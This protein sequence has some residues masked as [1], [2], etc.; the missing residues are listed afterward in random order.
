MFGIARLNTLAKAVSDALALSNFAYKSRLDNANAFNTSSNDNFGNNLGVSDTHVIVGAANEDDADGQ[1]TGKAYVYNLATGSLVYTFTNPNP[2]APST[3]DQFGWDVD[4]STN[5]AIVSAPFEDETGQNDAGKVYV[6]SMSTGTLT[7]TFNNPNIYPTAGLD[8]FGDQVA[9]AENYAL[10]GTL[11]DDPAGVGQGGA[12]FLYELATGTRVRTF[13]VASPVSN[14]YFGQAVDLT[15]TYSIVGAPG[16][17][18][19]SGAAYIYTNS[20][21]ALLYTLTNPNANTANSADGFG[22]SVALTNTHAIVG[23]PQEDDASGTS[24]GKAYVFR[25]SDGALVWTL[26]NPNAFG[27]S[28]ND[29]FGEKVSISDTHVLVSARSEADAGGSGSGKAYI[30]RISDGA[31]ETT[32]NNPNAFGTTL[33]D[34]FSLALGM[35]NTRAVISAYFEGDGGSNPT[36]SGTVGSGKAYIY[37]RI[38]SEQVS[39]P[40]AYGLVLTSEA[41]STAAT[42]V[43]PAAAQAG[44]VAVL[45]DFS[46][47]TTQTVPSGWTL[48][49][50]VTTTGLRTTISYKVLTAFDNGGTITGQALTSRKRMMVFRNVATTTPTITLSTPSAEATTVAPTSQSITGG[51]A[52]CIYFACYA[53]TTSTNPTRGWTGSANTHY[54]VSTVSTSG[55]YVKYLI[56]NTGA[57]TITP[58]TVTVTMS[59]AGSNSL[60]SFRMQIS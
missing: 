51:T 30:F 56:Y 31:L 53:K 15:D 38:T 3:T 48:I 9:I 22:G 23:A 29:A 12:A 8:Y 27:T 54:E 2:F 50:S 32:L 13:V 52:P 47:T 39:A 37:S 25:L 45:F 4:I 59:D 1:A 26:S 10:V 43:V 33:N 7:Y 21:G 20:T 35:N 46:S 40:A 6:Y 42:I 17:T 49:S 36:L 34:Q 55:I 19:N 44:D 41:T 18:S 57:N 24:S 28:V 5:W 58:E 16:R 14:D 11:Y 60:Q